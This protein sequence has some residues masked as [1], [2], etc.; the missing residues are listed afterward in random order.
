[1]SYR[2]LTKHRMR[3]VAVGLLLVLTLL[4]SAAGVWA[5]FNDSADAGSNAFTTGTIDIGTNPTT[6][7][8][9]LAGMAPGAAVTQLM[10]VQNAGSLQLRYAVT[11]SATDADGKALKDQLVLTVRRKD[12]TTPNVPCD[13]FDGTQLYTGDLDGTGGVIFGDVAQGAQTGDRSVDAGSDDKLCFRVSLPLAAG[14][15]VQSATTTATFTFT[16]EQTR[17]N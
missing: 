13:N 8:L 9:T 4:S 15:G 6:A 14:N 5:W 1:M 2:V 3:S 17:N 11:A 16:A 10:T 12:S 7:A